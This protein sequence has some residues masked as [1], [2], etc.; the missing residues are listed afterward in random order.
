[1]STTAAKRALRNVAGPSKVPRFVA[2]GA[3][4]QAVERGERIEVGLVEAGVAGERRADE[5]GVAA[6]AGTG[7]VGHAAEAD[8]VEGGAVAEGGERE[9]GV[10]ADVAEVLVTAGQERVL[11]TP[12]RG[13]RRGR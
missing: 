12:R 1:M 10:A 4:P 5:A 9:V 13:D 8:A 7:E 11:R 6:E 2:G 3:G